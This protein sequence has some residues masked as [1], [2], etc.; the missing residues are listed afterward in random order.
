MIVISFNREMMR[1]KALKIKCLAIALLAAMLLMT[2]CGKKKD[3]QPKE[4]PISD[5]ESIGTGADASDVESDA[6]PVSGEI[7]S[8]KPDD[9]G[10]ANTP[11]NNDTAE[12]PSKPASGTSVKDDPLKG[13]GV[14]G[15]V[16]KNDFT[17]ET[18]EDFFNN[19]SF[20]GDSVM[21]G[22]DLYSNRNKT[23]ESGSTFLTVTSFAARHAL[24]EVGPKSYHPTYNGEKM[25]VEDALTL[26]GSNKVF[27]F[28]GLNDV[29]VTPNS[30]YENYVE[31]LS[32]IREKNPNIDI[33]II[34]STY[35]VQN[36]GSM[37]AQTAASYRDQLQDLNVRLKSYCDEGN[38]F[39]VNVVSPLLNSSGFLD[40][41]YSSDNYVHLTNSAYAIW[42]QVIEAYANTLIST[43]LPPEVVFTEYEDVPAAAEQ[44]SVSGASAVPA[45]VPV[46][47]EPTDSTPAENPEAVADPVSP[48]EENAPASEELPE[49]V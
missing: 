40:D 9:T 2:A 33:F 27:V 1:K 48:D 19:A 36:P 15:T 38:A 13:S 47:E 46:P 12:K 32:R 23:Y 14:T 25:K 34:S 4:T 30:Y 8:E 6:T 18:I 42:A 49:E 21:Y 17:S 3:G 22:F 35:P 37:D 43:G 16:P 20:V 26:A 41:R 39:F 11:S 10:N 31:F 28:L 45:P 44:P 24:S 29:R 7:S 5:A